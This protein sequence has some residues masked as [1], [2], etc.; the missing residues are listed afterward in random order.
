MAKKGDAARASV[1]EGI[2]AAFAATGNYVGTQD[3]K[4]YVTAQDGAGGETLQFAISIT[5]PKT[6][7][8]AGEVGSAFGQGASSSAP[9][10]AAAPVNTE[11]SP[12]DKAAVDKLMAELGIID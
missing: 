6:P 11:L 5:M 9:A 3:K 10:V 2:V 7:I 8:A 4:I 12:E 1:M